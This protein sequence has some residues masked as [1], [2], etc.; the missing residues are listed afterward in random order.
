M[1]PRKKLLLALRTAILLVMAL[2]FFF[3]AQDGVKS[4]STSRSAAEFVLRLLT[5]GYDDL[6]VSQRRGC[7][8]TAERIVRKLAHF[9]EFAVLSSLLVRYFFVRRQN[10]RLLPALLTGWPLAVLYAC[11]DE[12]HQS[13]VA[14]RGPALLD[15]G[16]DAAGALVGA[17]I[18][19][20]LLARH[21]RKGEKR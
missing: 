1:T 12:L 19:L 4:S 8:K 6:P 13:F 18:T 2:I 21:M 9:T 10:G 7:R 14:G 16:I 3:S 11:T 20:A 5:P 15:V 17:L